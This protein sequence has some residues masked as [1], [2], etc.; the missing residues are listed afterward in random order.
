MTDVQIQPGAVVVG[1]DG[2]EGSR[3]ALQ[4]AVDEAAASH[5]RAYAVAVCADVVYTAP[6]PG[7]LEPAAGADPLA[8]ARAGL[9]QTVA[10]VLGDGWKDDVTLEVAAGSPA[11][12]L[13]EL[14]ESA[15]LLVVGASGHGAVLASLL[16]SVAEQLVHHAACPVTVVRATPPV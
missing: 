5:R 13:R 10:E 11:T 15:G 6:F 8:D 3:A 9:E 12:V 2:S 4:W 14:S 7:Y 1:V 16:G